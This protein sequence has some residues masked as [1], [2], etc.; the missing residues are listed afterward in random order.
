VVNLAAGQKT[1]FF[2][3]QRDNRALVRQYAANRNALD[4]FSYS[5]GFAVNAALGGAASVRAVDISP[6]AGAL[7]SENARLNGVPIDF[8]K[9]DVFS[10]LREAALSSPQIDLLILDPPKFARHVGEVEKAA[11]GYKDI[12]LAAMRLLSPG[13]I[14]FTF[15]CSGA[16]DPYLF[17][18]IAFSAAADS[19]RSVQVL[20]ALGAGE[21]HLVNIAHKE[22][23]YLKGLALRVL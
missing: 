23:D 21:D 2:L 20:R 8:V 19:G 18:Q 13:G 12:N 15:S 6:D 3:D 11:R 5:G 16:V 14:L 1:G 10:Y 4:C 17:R 7:V 22:G 9:A